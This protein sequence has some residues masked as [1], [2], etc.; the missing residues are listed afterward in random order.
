MTTACHIDRGIKQYRCAVCHDTGWIL[1]EQDV[2]DY[3]RGIVFAKSCERCRAQRRL[4]DVTGVPAEYSDNDISKIKWDIYGRDLSKLHKI[5]ED[6]VWHFKDRW[7]KMG[8]GIFL[9]SST[10]GS[11][12]TH[13][14]TALARSVMI[15][16]DV[17]MRFVT[18]ADYI[19]AIGSGI[20]QQQIDDLTAV[21][22][23]C[24]LLVIDDIGTGKAGDWQT[25]QMF[26]LINTRTSN[27]LITLYTSNCAV[28]E[29][30]TVD[31][32][33]KSRILRNSIVLQMP[34]VSIRN[35]QAQEQQSKFLAD[36]IGR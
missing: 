36:I 33:C 10:P 16:Y 34:E 18:A 29:L 21:Y 12:K 26:R 30:T 15:K 3:G 5:C 20:R 23:T 1:E 32:R 14:A 27:G 8:K 9:W 13:I 7:Q 31:E 4:S 35:Q 22:R 2:T 19:N 28:G 6:F 11:G 25:E 17:Q 24:D